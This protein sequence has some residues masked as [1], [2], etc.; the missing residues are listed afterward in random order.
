MTRATGLT[1]LTVASGTS[2][3]P[4]VSLWP[5]VP[6]KGHLVPGL[7]QSTRVIVVPRVSKGHQV[8]RLTRATRFTVASR[9]TRATK[10]HHVPE[11]PRS[12]RAQWGRHGAVLSVPREVAVPLHVLV[13]LT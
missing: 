4:A 11:L 9:A 8:P 2:R 10:G 13:S 1:R 5:P 6:P 7:T 12:D 3:S